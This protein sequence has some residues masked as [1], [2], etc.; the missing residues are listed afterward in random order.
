[1]NCVSLMELDLV[2]NE[3]QVLGA[4]HGLTY[5]EA[6]CDLLEVNC[7]Y[8]NLR[9]QCHHAEEHRVFSDGRLARL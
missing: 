8:V 3:V 1:M 2:V 7:G 4:K 9:W 6:D 5:S